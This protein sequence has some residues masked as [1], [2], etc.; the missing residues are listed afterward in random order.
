[1]NEQEFLTEIVTAMV[2]FTTEKKTSPSFS[3]R[4]VFIRFENPN[5]KVGATILDKFLIE[6]VTEKVLDIDFE[7][8]LIIKVH[9]PL[10]EAYYGKDVMLNFLNRHVYFKGKDFVEKIK[11][12]IETT[13]TN[14]K[15]ATKSVLEIYHAEATRNAIDYMRN[16]KEKVDKGETHP[17]HPLNK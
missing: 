14:V 10:Y 9:K 13:Q 4:S 7:Y 6:T 3:G 12:L 1:M 8:N 17:N 2:E 15:R 11:V 16:F 5:V